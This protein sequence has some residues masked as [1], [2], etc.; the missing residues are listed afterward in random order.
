M[1]H[2]T[3]IHS[4]SSVV[5]STSVW[6]TFSDC[7]TSQWLMCNRAQVQRSKQDPSCLERL[8]ADP[9]VCNAQLNG[10]AHGCIR[11]V[12]EA[13]VCHQEQWAFVKRNQLEL[14]ATGVLDQ[15]ELPGYDRRA[16]V[17]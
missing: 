10:R 14:L 1:Y 2:P 15:G 13:K 9:T 12:R 16:R 4:L 17:G 7:K 5:L 11:A 3:P 8:G 6:I